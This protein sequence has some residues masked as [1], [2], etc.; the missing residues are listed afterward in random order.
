MERG[1]TSNETK[2]PIATPK[3]KPKLEEINGNE[4]S[5][6]QNGNIARAYS[7]YILALK[8]LEFPLE[9]NFFL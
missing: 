7:S 4:E 9:V 5:L 3:V 6:K 8:D 2:S 1:K